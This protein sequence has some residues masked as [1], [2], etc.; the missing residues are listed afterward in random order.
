MTM[1]PSPSEL[2]SP[3]HSST[4]ISPTSTTSSAPST[5]RAK[6]LDPPSAGKS[7]KPPMASSRS[8]ERRTRVSERSSLRAVL[9][10]ASLARCEHATRRDQRSWIAEQSLLRRTRRVRVHAR[11]RTAKTVL[12]IVLSGVDASLDKSGASRPADRRFLEDTYVEA[13]PARFPGSPMEGARAWGSDPRPRGEPT[14][15][16]ARPRHVFV[17]QGGRLEHDRAR[18]SGTKT[19]W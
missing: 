9:C 5:T 16:H 10:P 12:S 14:R 6:R 13:T 18:R 8:S 19:R 17:E 11:P 3:A 4:S 15:N 1:V 2:T 7:P